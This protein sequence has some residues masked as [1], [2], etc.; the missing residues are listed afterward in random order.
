MMKMLA[1]PLGPLTMIWK[2]K[3]LGNR[4]IDLIHYKKYPGR[5]RG[6]LHFA[7]LGNLSASWCGWD[8]V[9]CGWLSPQSGARVRALR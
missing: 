3:I 8:G 9:T 6:I 7:I 1:Q 4:V 5:N 2:C